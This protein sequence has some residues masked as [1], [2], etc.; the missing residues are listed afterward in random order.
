MPQYPFPTDPEAVLVTDRLR[1]EPVRADLAP[2]VFELWEDASIYRYVP[3]EPPPSVEWLTERYRRLETRQSTAGD[4]A[5]VQ[6][7]V[8]LAAEPT[9]VGRVEATVEAGRPA[10]L[11]WMFGPAFWRQGF[12]T[13][14]TTRV[15]EH[16]ATAWGVTE[17]YVEIDERN[18]ASLALAGRLGFVEQRR[19]EDADFF[20]GTTSHERH[21]GRSLVDL[22]SPAG[23]GRPAGYGG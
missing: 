7:A 1:L 23:D 11:A 10:V 20:K 22:A 16:L 21:L 5:W 6:W 13:E 4:Q 3:E 18:V 12:G 19:V 8:R 9:Y 17:A 2:V 14:A 15:L